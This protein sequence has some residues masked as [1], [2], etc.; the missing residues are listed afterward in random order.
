MSYLEKYSDEELFSIFDSDIEEE[1]KSR[2]YEYGWHKKVQYAGDIYILVNPAF[3]NLVKIGYA[4]NVAKRVKSLN[5]NSGLPDPFHVYAT[6]RVKK[7]LEDLKLHKLIDSLDSDLRHA[8]NKEFYEMTPE[9]AYDI[10]S[11]IAQINGDEDLLVK[12]PLNDDF[13]NNVLGENVESQDDIPPRHQHYLNFWSC[14]NRA[15]AKQN[16]PFNEHKPLQ[17][18]WCDVGIGT[19]KA[20]LY[21]ALQMQRRRC[22]AVGIS[23]HNDKSI[24]D[25][26]YSCKDEIEQEVGHVLNW[27]RLDGKKASIVEYIIDDFDLNDDRHNKKLKQKKK[28][29]TKKQQPAK[30]KM[31]YINSVNI[32]FL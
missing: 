25:D 6:Y 18:H 1:I 3:P 27:D 31:Y 30:K 14:L 4:D 9:K 8:K 32:L 22:M 23:I 7:R 24:Y 10:L 20:H 21:I 17:Q 26:L 15:L 29:V 2:G 12:N 19:S 16:H 28:A 13:F 5:N 11:A